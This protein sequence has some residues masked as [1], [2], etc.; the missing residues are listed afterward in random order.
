MR[1]QGEEQ[2]LLIRLFFTKEK[3]DTEKS[4]KHGEGVAPIKAV[5]FYHGENRRQ[6]EET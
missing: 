6:S 5:F 3:E 1:F 2:D 4:L